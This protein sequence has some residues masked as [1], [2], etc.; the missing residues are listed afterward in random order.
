LLDFN[1]LVS[2]GKN[3]P[4]KEIEPQDFRFPQIR[5]LFDL[6]K[7]LTE[8]KATKQLKGRSQKSCVPFISW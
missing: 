3:K 4:S 7:S 5:N 1:Q 8:V 6:N 2:K